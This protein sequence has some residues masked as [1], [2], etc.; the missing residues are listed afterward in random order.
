MHLQSPHGSSCTGGGKPR[1][2]GPRRAETVSTAG[3]L[4]PVFVRCRPRGGGPGGSSRNPDRRPRHPR[5]RQF[6]RIPAVPVLDC[7]HGF[8]QGGDGFRC[9]RRRRWSGRADGR[10]RRS[11]GRSA[12]RLVG[13]DGSA[14]AE[15]PR[16][17][18]RAV[19]SDEPGTAGFI[20]RGVRPAG[21]VHDAGDGGDGSK[22]P[23]VA[24]SIGWGCQRS[25]ATGCASTRP[26][27]VPPTCRQRWAAGS[28][29]LA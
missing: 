5:E 26:A 21:A 12:R 8:R 16:Q 1:Q 25:C 28:S 27:S 22:A 24:C 13:A 9:S 3:T 15:D 14:G 19:Q 11:R 29:S 17:R 7:L 2:F 18:R 6:V 10:N 23:F 4:T 20:P